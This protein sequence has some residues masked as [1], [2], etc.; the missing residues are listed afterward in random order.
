MEQDST[1]METESM[2]PFSGEALSHP[3]E[4][5]SASGCAASSRN[6]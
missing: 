4:A 2:E 3:I 6:R 5:V 1:R